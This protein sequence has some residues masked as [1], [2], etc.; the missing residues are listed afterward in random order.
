LLLLLLL[1]VSIARMATAEYEATLE[2]ATMEGE[3][4]MEVRMG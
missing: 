2:G 4:E 3:E 1:T